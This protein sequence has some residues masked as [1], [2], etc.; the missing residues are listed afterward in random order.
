[1]IKGGQL[2]VYYLS[3]CMMS[4][5]FNLNIG[6]QKSRFDRFVQRAHSTLSSVSFRQFSIRYKMLHV[7]PVV[8]RSSHTTVCKTVA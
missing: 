6:L 4:L 2:F 8:I 7:S 5:G 3:Q 1:M